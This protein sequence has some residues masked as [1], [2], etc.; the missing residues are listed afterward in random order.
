[1]YPR[2]ERHAWSMLACMC[3]K[4]RREMDQRVDVWSAGWT[5]RILARGAVLLWVCALSAAGFGCGTDPASTSG[6]APATVIGDETGSGS[7]GGDA[8]SGPELD[9]SPGGEGTDPTREPPPGVDAGGVDS[10][11][12]TADSGA[13]P[14]IDPDAG[15]ADTSAPAD[16][17]PT[18]PID[19]VDPPTV[20]EI[21]DDGVDNSGNGFADCDDPTCV[22]D[23]HCAPPLEREI[24]DD[25]IDNDRDGLYDCADPDC[26]T[27]LACAG[28]GNC[29]NASDRAW[30]QSAGTDTFSSGCFIGCA[31]VSDRRGCARG[32][33]ASEPVS[34]ACADCFAGIFD[35]TLARCSAQCVPNPNSVQCSTCIQSQCGTDFFICSGEILTP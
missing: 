22:D 23:P 35:C 34:V 25:G 32:C 4:M 2:R 17:D 12:H 1:M 18:E 5:R 28:R 30:V 27:S 3:T 7:S 15:A 24:C 6:E 29:S 14:V 20:P 13:P 8:D 26:R 19:P 11:S 16:V 9:A 33:L 10:G 21:C 31:T